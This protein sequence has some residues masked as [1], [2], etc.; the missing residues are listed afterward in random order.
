MLPFVLKKMA[1]A[2]KYKNS[3]TVFQEVFFVAPL[4]L[5]ICLEVFGT[6]INQKFIFYWDIVIEI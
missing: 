3:W 5:G 1:F 2:K 4:F 6:L